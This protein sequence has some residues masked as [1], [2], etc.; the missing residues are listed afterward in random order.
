MQHSSFFF[1]F[2]S[3]IFLPSSC[4][5]N[6]Q[7]YVYSRGGEANGR[8]ETQLSQQHASLTKRA[9]FRPPAW[10]SEGFQKSAL[11][12]E[13]A[14]E[15][16]HKP[17]RS[18]KCQRVPAALILQPRPRDPAVMSL[19]PSLHPFFRANPQHLHTAHPSYPLGQTHSLWLRDVSKLSELL[20]G[21]NTPQLVRLGYGLRLP[22]GN[23]NFSHPRSD[24][25]SLTAG[26]CP[27]QE[28]HQGLDAF[29]A[30]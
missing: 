18:K 4:F 7:K 11:H 23:S 26:L 29:P 21:C 6:E 16:Q 27:Q 30:G 19:F 17:C 24:F 3:I 20:L 9:T 22:T 25:V 14:A 5:P 13:R 8:A 12:T 1:F 15:A 2:C 10:L 28:L